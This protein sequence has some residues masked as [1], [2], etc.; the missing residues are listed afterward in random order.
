VGGTQYAWGAVAYIGA[1]ECSG[2]EETVYVPVRRP[3]GGFKWEEGR[4][5]VSCLVFATADPSG[6]FYDEAKGRTIN[7]R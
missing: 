3:T 6:K 2:V 5:R 7:L 4:A 1:F